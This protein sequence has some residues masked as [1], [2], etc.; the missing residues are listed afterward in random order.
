MHMAPVAELSAIIRRF[1]EVSQ[2]FGVVLV[3]KVAQ[4]VGWRLAGFE[5]QKMVATRGGLAQLYALLQRFGYVGAPKFG[6]PLWWVSVHIVVGNWKQRLFPVKVSRGAIC[7]VIIPNAWLVGGAKVL[8]GDAWNF[9][10][11]GGLVFGQPARCFRIASK[12]EMPLLRRPR[13]ARVAREARVRVGLL[14]HP[15]TRIRRIRIRNVAA[16]RS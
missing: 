7:A 4:K 5:H 16:I 15:T 2:P 12:E 6:Y 8:R 13:V 1:A 3:V 10:N 11:A 9:V 14:G